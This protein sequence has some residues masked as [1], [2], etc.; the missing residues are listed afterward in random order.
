MDEEKDKF[1]VRVYGLIINEKNEILV[2]DETYFGFKM[3]KFPGGGLEYG[4]G[5]VEC[6]LREAVEEFGQPVEVLDHFYTTD[7]FQESTFFKGYQVICI[8]YL[9]RFIS[10]IAFKISVIPFDFPDSGKNEQS[11]RLIRLSELSEDHFT[12]PADKKVGELIQRKLA[13]F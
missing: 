3:T 8:Y 13:E 1:T 9:A 2:S 4:E 11:F 12:F 10:E 7:F 5:P 6:L